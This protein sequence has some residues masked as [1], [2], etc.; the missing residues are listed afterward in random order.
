M[1]L[2]PDSIKI[3]HDDVLAKSISD[4]SPRVT[5]QVSASS[6]RVTPQVSAS[7]P[8]VTPQVSASSLRVTPQVNASSPKVTPQV[9]TLYQGSHL[10]GAPQIQPS[11]SYNV[12]SNSSQAT[13]RKKLDLN[14]ECK[15][16][17]CPKGIVAY[18]IVTDVYLISHIT[19]IIIEIIF[20]LYP[21]P[22]DV[23]SKF[24]RDDLLWGILDIDG[25]MDVLWG[26]LDIEQPDTQTIKKIV[27]PS[28]ELIYSYEKCF[29][30]HQNN[31]GSRHSVVPVVALLKKLLL[32]PY[33]AV[34]T[35][36]SLVISSRL[37]QVPYQQQTML[38]ID[39]AVENIALTTPLA[40]SSDIA[41][42]TGGITQVLI[43]EDSATSS[44]QYCCDGCSTVPIL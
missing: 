25:L 39:D 42:A 43:E 14:R 2:Y 17:G 7:S 8:R 20:T 30:L 12:P 13:Q 5:P 1:N 33:E 18:G 31:T 24:M 35:S 23:G 4:S 3:G 40:A 37:L 44:E 38:G 27:V 11:S 6:L 16:N 29:V 36:T 21:G 26:I 22:S 19:Y 9:T 15:L 28:M 41:S 34:Q 32:A 10:K